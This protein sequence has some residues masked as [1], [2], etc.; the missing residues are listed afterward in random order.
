MALRGFGQL[1]RAIMEVV[2]SADR[3]VTGRE[4][5]D[6][7]AHTRSV[8][9]TT[10]LT[11]MDRLVRKGVLAKQRAGRAHRYH[12]RVSRDAYT[13]TLMAAV[14]GDAADPTAALLHF[15]DQLPPAEADGLR[16]ALDAG[17]PPA[18]PTNPDPDGGARP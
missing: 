5:V 1:E 12:A 4:V 14:L 11:V 15:V 13:A 17:R 7:L 6:D 10:V 18:A 3:P 8:A 2:W 9:Y 16:A